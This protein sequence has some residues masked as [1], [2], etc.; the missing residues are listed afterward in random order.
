MNV[1]TVF[2]MVRKVAALRAVVAAI[3]IAAA[4]IATTG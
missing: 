3:A 4:A 2:M 1:A